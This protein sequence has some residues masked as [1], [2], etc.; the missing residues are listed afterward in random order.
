MG[1]LFLKNKDMLQIYGESSYTKFQMTRNFSAN[2]LKNIV[3]FVTA[4]KFL[5]K[6][7]P[8]MVL[9]K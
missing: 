7:V 4:L 9:K 8:F 2:T 1:L 3:N 6:L 5:I